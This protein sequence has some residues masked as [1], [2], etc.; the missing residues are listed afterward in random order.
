MKYA[1]HRLSNTYYHMRRRC[2]NPEN[3]AYK[4]YGGRGIKVCEEWATFD[5]F[6]RDME[7]SYQDGLTLDRIDNSKGYSKENCRWSTKVEQNNNS[8]KNRIVEYVGEKRTMAEW[9]RHLGLKS[10]TVRQRFYGYG[11]P[12]E[13]CFNYQ[14]K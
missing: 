8:R 2:S 3:I 9:I 5:G 4:N 14:T 11:W 13:K 6:K 10:S 1:H 12:I 7:A